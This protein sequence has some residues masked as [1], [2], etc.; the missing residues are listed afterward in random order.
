MVYARVPLSS[1]VKS[2]APKIAAATAP[3]MPMPISHFEP[4]AKAA[5]RSVVLAATSKTRPDTQAP[6]GM[7]TRIGWMG[8][9]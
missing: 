8:W 2:M 5:G 7:V 6:M 4:V 3:M 1:V 9:P